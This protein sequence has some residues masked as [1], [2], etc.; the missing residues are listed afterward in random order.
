MFRKAVYQ[1]NQSEEQV[2]CR[3]LGVLKQVSPCKPAAALIQSRGGRGILV[4]LIKV[5]HSCYLSYDY[6]FMTVNVG[7]REF[8]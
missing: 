8:Q 7:N 5:I 3:F 2:L 1:P 4:L 6:G